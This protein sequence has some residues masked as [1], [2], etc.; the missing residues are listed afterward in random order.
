MGALLFFSQIPSVGSAHI[1]FFFSISFPFPPFLFPSIL[2]IGSRSPC[3]RRRLLVGR[4]RAYSSGPVSRSSLPHSPLSGS[5]PTPASPTQASLALS[6]PSPSASSAPAQSCKDLRPAQIRWFA[7]ST[8]LLLHLRAHL[9]HPTTSPWLQDPTM[10]GASVTSQRGVVGDARCA[11]QER[12][13]LD[14]S[15]SA[16]APAHLALHWP[17]CGGSWMKTRKAR[18]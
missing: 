5:A 4:V 15:H 10:D 1:F 3:R 9:S 6:P 11:G 14:A 16:P 17:W 2:L 7:A 13:P 8:A 18:D 12:A